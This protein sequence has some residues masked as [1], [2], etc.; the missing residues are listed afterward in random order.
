MSLKQG[1]LI[2]AIGGFFD[3]Y[4]YPGE[5]YRCQIK[6]KLKQKNK[7]ETYVKVGDL[8]EFSPGTSGQGIIE[9]ILPR[10]N[11]LQ[12]PE[13]ANVSQLISVISARNPLPDWNL[14]SRHLVVAESNGIKS[15]ICLNKKDLVTNNELKEISETLNMYPYKA[16]ITSALS[17]EGMDELKDALENHISVFSGSSGVGKSSLINTLR[18]DLN[19][20]TGEVSEKGKR[21][22][23]T[24]R[25]VEILPLNGGM[26]VDT[27]GFS[28]LDLSGNEVD[29]PDIFFPEILPYRANCKFRDCYHK[30]EPK[31]SVKE[32]VEEGLISEMRY[33]HYLSFLSEMK[34]SDKKRM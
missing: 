22:R 15:L 18:P 31:C 9:N 13:V 27:P 16:I 32:A 28:K 25:R 29:C 17:G 19:L 20:E 3:V 23:H 11:C 26:I 6:G 30:D 21:G 12:R 33:Q 2:R 1:R 5:I 7:G 34:N 10:D 4:I 8:V 14:L 24:T